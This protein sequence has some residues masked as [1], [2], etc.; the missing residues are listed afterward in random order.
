MTNAE[1]MIQH[2]H[3]F[4]DIGCYVTSC[5]G[6]YDLL[7]NGKYVGTVTS[8]SCFTALENWLDMERKDP[9]ELGL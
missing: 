8:V 4:S 6:D 3:K 7:L 2:G 5:N 1:W 9:E